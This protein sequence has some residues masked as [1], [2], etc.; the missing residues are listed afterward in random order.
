MKLLIINYKICIPLLKLIAFLD[1]IDSGYQLTY[2]SLQ[3]QIETI[4]MN[5]K[6]LKYLTA[7]KQFGHFGK[8]AESCFVSQPTLS[9]GIKKLEQEL[10]VLLIERDNRSVRLTDVGEQVAKMSAEIVLQ[11]DNIRDFAK[12]Q[13][14]PLAG[15]CKLGVIPTIAPYYLPKIVPQLK[16][17]LPNI[18]WHFSEFQTWRMLE[19]IESGELDVG[20]LATHESEQKFEQVDLFHETFK[21]VMPKGHQLKLKKQLKATDL[22]SARVLLLTEGHCF[23]D[24]ALEVCSLRGVN[25]DLDIQATSLETLRQM[26]VAGTGITLL[27][28][29]SVKEKHQRVGLEVRDLPK[30]QPKRTISLIWRKN[31]YRKPLMVQ[32][33]KILS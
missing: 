33:K 27:P 17:S 12:Y 30:P 13:T 18:D 24:Q 29:M 6:F 22:E 3:Y 20:I 21:L 25:A 23:R 14:D 11:V 28:E 19:A 4:T 31:F 16:K 32:V 15:E 1:V 9:A 26:I 8:A 10:D 7:I 2:L 5:L